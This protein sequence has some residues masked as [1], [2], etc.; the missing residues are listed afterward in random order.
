MPREISTAS[1]T[2]GIICGGGSFPVM[3]ARAAQARGRSVL[4]I[5]LAG[6]ADPVIEE[7]PHVW[8]HLGEV[9][10]VFRA[11]EEAGARELVLVGSVQRPSAKDVRLDWVGLKSVA[12]LGKMLAGG[13]DQVLAGLIG[14]LEGHGYAVRGLHEVAP[15]LLVKPGALGELEPDDQAMV[16]MARARDLLAAMGPFD[17]GQ[18]AVVADG[19]VLAVEAAEGTDAML[20]RIAKLRKQKRLRGR[21]GVLV[22]MAKPGQD[23]RVDLPA[24]GAR[25]LEGAAEAKLSGIALQ[26][27]RTLLTDPH[28]LPP[29]AD[30]AGL[31]LFGFGEM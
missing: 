2:L 27:G 24:I 22:K 8:V 10:K 23:L 25:T 16:D 19:R 7:F 20:R 9:G 21:G 12:H 17:V 26:A 14:F 30:A 18:G 31:F 11:C 5:G 1:G 28:A 6:A 3:V 15:E 29:A 13:D 4:M